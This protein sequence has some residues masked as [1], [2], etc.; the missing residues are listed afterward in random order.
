MNTNLIKHETQI[1][2]SDLKEQEL[3]NLMKKNSTKEARKLLS[4]QDAKKLNVLPLSIFRNNFQSV[5]TVATNSRLDRDRIDTIKFLTNL[6][7]KDI[8]VKDD[9][10]TNIIFS[11]YHSDETIIEESVVNL[12][13]KATNEEKITQSKEK[14]FFENAKNDEGKFLEDILKFAISTGAS[15]LHIIP[16]SK[17]TL[18][19]LR[20]GTGFIYLNDFKLLKSQHMVLIRRIKVLASLE[21]DKKDFPQDGSFIIPELNKFAIRVSLMPTIYGEKAV[22]RLHSFKGVNDINELGINDEV[23]YTLED[24]LNLKG[25]AMLCAGPTGSGK[26]TTLYAMVNYLKNKGLNVVTIEDPVELAIDGISQTSLNVSRGFDYKDALCAILRQDPDVIMLGEIRD[27]ISAK[28]LFQAVFSGHKVLSTIHAGNILEIFLRLKSLNVSTIDMAEGLKFLSYQE[29]L[30][31]LCLAC[32]QKDEELSKKL[33]F[34]VFQEIGCD[35]CNNSHTCSKVLALETLTSNE[36]LKEILLRGEILTQNDLDNI[37]T[38]YPFKKYLFELLKGKKI[39]TFTFGAYF[40]C[41]SF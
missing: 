6:D 15:D 37:K 31:S 16:T 34:D 32:A 9:N 41:S 23:L 36:K 2:A 26:T 21:L 28:Y 3:L 20:V 4:Y 29:L 30:P 27:E 24:F 18:V 33:N 40:T 17:S 25:G 13:K 14:D 11:V 8:L 39:S 10:F 5:L 38:Y 7:V 12:E 35:A 22:L 19:K 1:I